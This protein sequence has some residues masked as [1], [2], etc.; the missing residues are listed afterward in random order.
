MLNQQLKRDQLAKFLP[1]PQLIRAFEELFTTVYVSTG[2]NVDEALSEAQSASARAGAVGDELARVLTLLNSSLLSPP[3]PP[4]GLIEKFTHPQESLKQ[5]NLITGKEALKQANVYI[6]PAALGG[7]AS[8]SYYESAWP[9]VVSA[10]NGAIAAA[11]VNYSKYVRIGRLVACNFSITIT[12]NG[13]GA[14]SVNISLPFKSA[15]N[16]IGVFREPAVTG[17]TGAIVTNASQTG[18]MVFADNSYPGGNNYNLVGNIT[19]KV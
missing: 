10:G 15:D 14:S 19:Y 13:T 1:N 8:Q 3:Q 4:I 16:E 9:A 2:Q 6:P 17:R 18:L 11:T 12:N 5:P 7:C